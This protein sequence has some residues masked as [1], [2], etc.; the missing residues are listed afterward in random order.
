M[1]TNCLKKESGFI[2]K[3]EIWLDLSCIDHKSVIQARSD[4]IQ[5]T[6]TNVLLIL[7]AQVA[8]VYA[9]ENAF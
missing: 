8:R 2:T 6:E 7:D 9:I 5:S 3:L 4:A 1:P